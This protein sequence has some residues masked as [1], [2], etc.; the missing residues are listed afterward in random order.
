MQALLIKPAA[1]NNR[2]NRK[3]ISDFVSAGA[4]SLQMHT[5]EDLRTEI[6]SLR[7]A[8]EEVIVVACGGDG[9]VHLALNAIA[10]LDVDLAVVP[11]GTGNDFARYLGIKSTET[12]VN[13]LSFGLPTPIDVGQIQL[14]NGQICHYLGI[15]SCGFDAQVNERA[16]GYR[17]PSGTLKYLAAVL[18]ELRALRAKHLRVTTETLALDSRYTLVAIGNTNSYGGGMKVCPTANASDGLF[19]LTFVSE[20]TRRLLVSVLP[21]VFW[22]GHVNHPKVS[23][24]ISANVEVS[25]EDFLVYADGERVG[26][27]PAKFKVLPNYIRVWR[28]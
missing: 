7:N 1:L 12:A 26:S 18:A 3:L 8:H 20:V 17:G 15:A 25:G 11:L 24:S 6:S 27:G 14:A 13:V 2:S 19:E 5:V 22:G 4:V 16:N 21:R 28:G 10:G 23:Q 9:T